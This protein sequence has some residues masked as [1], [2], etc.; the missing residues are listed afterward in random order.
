MGR[1]RSLLAH[2]RAPLFAA[3]L[4]LLLLSPALGAGYL[5][6]DYTFQLT[7]H[8]SSQAIGL[9]RPG[10]DLFNFETGDPA[11]FAAARA[12]GIWPWWVAPNFRLAFFRPLSSSLHALEFRHLGRVPWAQHLHS[13]LWYAA[14]V[15][16]VGATQR[17]ILGAGLV[18]GVA[19]AMYAIDDAHVLPALWITHRNALLALA[20]GFAAV[21]LWDRRARPHEGG[22]VPSALAGPALFAAAL[23]AG[24][25]AF[26]ALAW[27]V[28]HALL[29]DPRPRET[30]AREFAPFVAV[31]A[32]WFALYRGLGYGAAG[33]GF[34]LDPLRQPGEFL[35]ALFT[36]MPLLLL[37]QF[38]LPPADLWMQQPIRVQVIASIAAYAALGL[39]ALWLRRTLR[40]DPRVPFLVTGTLLSLVPVCATW[41]SD[42]LLLAS[43]FGA[44]SLL[45][46]A[47]THAKASRALVISVIAAHGV[48]AGALT[49]LKVFAVQGMFGGIVTR[50]A[51][52][53]PLGAGADRAEV[54]A[55]TAPDL[56]TPLYASSVHVV[57]RGHAPPLAI[58][59]LSV[60]VEGE[61]TVRRVDARALE[62]TLTRGFLHDAMSQTM[63]G[64]PWNFHPNQAI[65]A[66]TM[67]ATPTALTEDGRPRTVRFEFSRALE[68]PALRWVRWEGAGFVTW[69]P[70]PVGASVTLPPIDLGRA[71]S[72][73]R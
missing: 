57:S 32:L 37:S 31:S 3:L 38:A 50:A 6:D 30:R 70:P 61:L 40:G 33:G 59:T 62:L 43:G 28:A 72:G 35:G 45:A 67:R 27:I 13:L 19:V 36:R 55:L 65:D 1:L 56:L 21:L 53:L 48:I 7:L 34:Y 10:W 63:R 25:A 49:P 17:R 5:L 73:S 58:R 20:L 26:G 42:R 29:L 52:T 9:G 68:D 39:G 71:M 22:R 44:F 69:T 14:L 54:V 12:H 15:M 16:I 51:D 8:P 41:P 24:E 4:A 18:S 64:A 23:A 66:G 60:H 47:V 11:H 46:L 2:P